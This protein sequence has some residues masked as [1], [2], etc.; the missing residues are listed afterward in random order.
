MF[1]YFKEKQLESNEIVVEEVVVKKEAAVEKEV[2]I[3]NEVAVEKEALVEKKVVVAKETVKTITTT[4][5]K[6]NIT[7]KKHFLVWNHVSWGIVSL[8]VYFEK[9]QTQFYL[10][11]Q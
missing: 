11:N 4:K 1:W 8:F 5:S 10:L 7:R 6:I 9:T 2:V 3:E